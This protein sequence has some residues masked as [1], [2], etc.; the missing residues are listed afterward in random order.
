MHDP[1]ADDPPLLVVT[2][3]SAAT[4]V[5][6]VLTS[7]SGLLVALAAVPAALVFALTSWVGNANPPPLSSRLWAFIIGASVTV[8]VSLALSFAAEPWLEMTGISAYAAA[9]IIEEAVKGGALWWLARRW[10]TF[11]SPLSGL[12]YA[13]LVAGGFAFTEN[14][15]YFSQT[16]DVDGLLTTFAVRGLVLPFAH[17]LFTAGIGLALGLVAGRR[18]YGQVSAASMLMLASAYSLGAVGHGLWNLFSFFDSYWYLPAYLSGVIVLLS[19]ARRLHTRQANAF[20]TAI[21]AAGDQ[22][23]SLDRSILTDAS[24]RRSLRSQLERDQVQALAVWRRLW[25]S[26]AAG[27]NVDEVSRAAQEWR[28]LWRPTPVADAL[29]TDLPNADPVEES[30]E[31]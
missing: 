21:E 25:A 12:V 22:L 14:I 2:M 16:A 13:L 10:T 23:D 7:F 5:V 6:L 27:A 18:K 9:G 31:D 8:P 3:G 11:D 20:N 4:L 29:S 28:E 24:A 26:T 1:R 17:P 30:K 15:L 19:V